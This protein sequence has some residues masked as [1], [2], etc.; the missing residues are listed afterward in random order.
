[1]KKQIL[2]LFLAVLMVFSAFTACG[3][4]PEMVGLVLLSQPTK[5]EYVVGETFDF[6]GATLEATYD[7]ESTKVIPVT[8]D[9]IG[10]VPA[11]TQAGLQKIE[12]SYTE[13]SVTKTT[14]IMIKVSGE[15]VTSL[16]VAKE[17]AK[18]TLSAY[19]NALKVYF[20]APGQTPGAPYPV[21]PADKDYATPA[22]NL[23]EAAIA[24]IDA[25]GDA[26]TVYNVVGKAEAELKNLD[27]YVDWYAANTVSEVE[28]E[29]GF[30]F[31][32][33]KKFYKPTE[34]WDAYTM[35]KYYTG[36]IL[37]AETLADIDALLPIEY[38]QLSIIDEIVQAMMS[39]KWP[40]D[41]PLTM[42]DDAEDAT[43]QAYFK[44]NALLEEAFNTGMLDPTYL[45]EF[46]KRLANYDFT[47]LN[48]DIE[49]AYYTEVLKNYHDTD[50]NTLNFLNVDMNG[51]N[52]PSG[53]ILDVFERIQMLLAARVEAN[54]A[55]PDG[56]PV[57]DMEDYLAAIKDLTPEQ[58][59]DKQAEIALNAGV[60]SW[61]DLVWVDYGYINGLPGENTEIILMKKAAVSFDE[62]VQEVLDKVG[63][64]AD[65]N[66]NPVVAK[67]PLAIEIKDLYNTVVANWIRPYE[68]DKINE[69][70]ID[71]WADLLALKQALDR[72]EAA[73]PNAPTL[74]F[75]NQVI[76]GTSDTIAN[77]VTK[78][79]IEAQR[80]TADTFATSANIP[81]DAMYFNGTKNVYVINNYDLLLAA[82][83]RMA[84]LEDAK[85]VANA[86]GA[87]VD[88]INAIGKVIYGKFEA[89][90]A[91]KDAYLE[92]QGSHSLART[93]R[94]N[95]VRS[96]ADTVEHNW[97]QILGTID[98]VGEDEITTTIEVYDIYHAAIARKAQLEQ[99]YA[100]AYTAGNLVTKIENIGTVTLD[101]MNVGGALYE[102]KTAFDVWAQAPTAANGNVGY[103]IDEENAQ[104]IL[105]DH[106]TNYLNALKTYQELLDQLAKVIELIKALPDPSVA[107]DAEGAWAK[108]E[109]ARQAFITL[110]AMNND[111]YYDVDTG[112]L[113][114]ATTH[115]DTYKHV[116]DP[117]NGAD[118]Y[119][120]LVALEV[121]IFTIKLNT[122]VHNTVADATNLYDEYF[123]AIGGTTVRPTD[124]QNLFVAKD[125]FVADIRANLNTYDRVATSDAIMAGVLVAD[126]QTAAFEAITAYYDA[127]IVDTYNNAIRYLITGSAV[128]GYD[129]II[130]VADNYKAAE[131][132]DQN[133]NIPESYNSIT[134]LASGATLDGFVAGKV[135]YGQ[136]VA[137]T[138]FALT[139]DTITLQ[140]CAIDELEIAGAT[141]TN[142]ALVGD[143]NTV[144]KI[145]TATATSVTSDV[146]MQMTF[147]STING[148]TYTITSADAVSIEVLADGTI[149][150]D[151]QTIDLDIEVDTTVATVKPTVVLANATTSGTIDS[152]VTLNNASNTG[153]IV[154]TINV[155]VNDSPFDDQD[156]DPE[157]GDYTQ[158][159]Y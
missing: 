91:A 56:T 32:E 24:A 27:N 23:Y 81:A 59:I 84:Q 25:A 126:Y 119:A 86:E 37:R 66:Y 54:D 146:A 145:T 69:D 36:L 143:N 101:S 30:K 87:L 135:I 134:V 77:T 107:S 123:A 156:K 102:A 128:D 61:N 93:Y 152:N 21:L 115:F 49:S 100:N 99:A 138:T 155:D 71:G 50:A 42:A 72:I 18:N 31:T 15:A 58:I 149:T 90:D 3:S 124:T 139:G 130:Y 85:A 57:M 13:G 29:F 105:G 6:T 75:G 1:M 113:L 83:E 79:D 120:K 95:G 44:V 22:K 158:G 34:Y 73:I 8:S 140:N 35:M 137:T 5:T 109:E 148:I 112:D 127:N 96:S 67:S 62:M 68:I 122:Y 153:D 82:E 104:A 116:V 10:V 41:L 92:L 70:L 151:A 53:I 117:D 43:I 9:M 111:P 132:L 129:L 47:K 108:V 80:A 131:M 78:T 76:L 2:V 26:T 65:G 121:E 142:V 64:D 63:K 33:D 17:S 48:V 74:T 141:A 157:D 11:F 147:T 98:V 40:I 7:D 110:C 125:S 150:I 88:K 55:I 16:S 118:L 89:V 38:D 60:A 39:C 136:T 4:D 94:F 51:V 114:P 14:Y 144:G 45:P 133:A 103:D 106:Y 12:V 28:N 20:L 52:P 159:I 46:F 154:P 19:Y 97:R